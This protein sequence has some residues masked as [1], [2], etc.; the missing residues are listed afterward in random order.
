MLKNLVSLSVLA[1]ALLTFSTAFASPA[2][3]GDEAFLA[4]LQAPQPA[5]AP[6][7]PAL[8]GADWVPAP[9]PKACTFGC[10]TCS[11]GFG[12]QFCTTCNGVKSCG[13]C[14]PTCGF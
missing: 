4:S 11:T 6:E 12:K 14:A 7:A 1:V 13:S 10:Q 9:V 8:P 2:P 5:A 3:A